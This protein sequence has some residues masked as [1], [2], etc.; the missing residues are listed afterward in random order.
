MRIGWQRFGPQATTFVHL[1]LALFV[2]I[3]A[4]MRLLLATIEPVELFIEVFFMQRF[5]IWLGL[6][7]SFWVVEVEAM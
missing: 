3:A 7:S 2:V 6:G 4:E 5:L 1:V